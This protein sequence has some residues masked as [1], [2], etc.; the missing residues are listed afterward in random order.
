MYPEQIRNLTFLAA[1]LGALDLII[2][3]I[4]CKLCLVP[5]ANGV[6]VKDPQT[7]RIYFLSA[8]PTGDLLQSEELNENDEEEDQDYGERAVR[9]V[10]TTFD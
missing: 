3:A 5:S 4:I 7:D 1:F 8:I 9:L 2:C 10:S 6:I